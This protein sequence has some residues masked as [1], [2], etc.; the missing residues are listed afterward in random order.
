MKEGAALL[1]SKFVAFDD[2]LALV[3]ESSELFAETSAEEFAVSASVL[4]DSPELF[5]ETSAEEFAVS[6]SVSFVG[7]Q[8]NFRWLG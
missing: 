6:A 3:F 2:S 4:F 8:L 7:L 5:A 1:S